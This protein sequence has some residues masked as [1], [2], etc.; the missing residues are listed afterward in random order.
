MR[1]IGLFSGLG[2]IAMNAFA[3]QV[4]SQ[5][6]RTT[7]WQIFSMQQGGMAV[8]VAPDAGAN[9]FSIRYK[10]REILKQADATKNL[11]GFMYGVPL[12]Y[13]FPNRV[14]EGKFTFD[15]Q[16]YEFPPNLGPNAIHGLV[17]AAPFKVTRSK[18][19]SE[20]AS[21]RCE[22][23]FEPGTEWYRRFPHP[24]NLTI[25]ISV[26][27]NSVRWT[28]TVDNSQGKKPVPFGF[29][30]HPWFVYQGRRENTY[31][32]VPATHWMEAREL[33]PTGKL[34]ELAGSRFD[35]RRPRSLKNFVIDDV[36]FGMRP[37]QPAVIDFRD[38]ALQI[39]LIAT[40][41]FTHL[42]VY[43]PDEPWFCVENQTSSTDAHN[44]YAKGQKR[45]AN[46]QIAEPGA[47]RTGWIE[48]RFKE[49]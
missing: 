20:Q 6:D 3:G 15:G 29:G 2:L 16:T 24:H 31:L 33:L 34:L 43:T 30:I 23:P 19:D 44:L 27:D 14:R 21:I 45:E 26:R 37:D 39:A 11:P 47:T 22:L 25:D 18:F 40:S 35:A 12:L 48:F 36:Y 1:Y 8:L 49:Y 42:V 4:T 28:Y 5:V 7:G 46:L 32:T 9:A 41:E 17:A 38:P 10:N 13:P